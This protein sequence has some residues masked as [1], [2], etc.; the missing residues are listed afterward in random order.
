MRCLTTGEVDVRLRQV[1]KG[2]PG[3]SGAL[4]G[5]LNAGN[6]LPVYVSVVTVVS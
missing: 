1:Q 5:L 4:L 2:G 3:Y 6:A